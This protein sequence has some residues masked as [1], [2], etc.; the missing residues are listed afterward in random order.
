MGRFHRRSPFITFH[1]LCQIS[2]R[3][4]WSLQ[5]LQSWRLQ[6]LQ[7]C[8]FWSLGRCSRSF[9]HNLFGSLLDPMLRN[10]NL[11][12]DSF[13][14]LRGGIGVWS[15]HGL[16]VL[17][18]CWSGGDCE[19]FKLNQYQFSQQGGWW[20][21]WNIWASYE[22]FSCSVNI[23]QC[24]RW[25]FKEQCQG[26]ATQWT[27]HS[28]LHHQNHNFHQTWGDFLGP[29]HAAGGHF[30]VRTNSLPSL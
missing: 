19:D 17:S 27:L 7:A 12:D 21:S 10:G 16:D 14:R 30:L 11:L 3:H 9:E 18:L 29:M 20:Q 13:G 24:Q 15:S 22:P 28:H 5:G 25:D 2:W 1:T 6:G 4:R 23:V 8:R 26:W